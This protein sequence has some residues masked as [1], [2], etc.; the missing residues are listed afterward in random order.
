[1][2]M[3]IMTCSYLKQ[4][5]RNIM[6]C[7]T[8]TKI[9]RVL[10]LLVIL[11]LCLWVKYKN[12]KAKEMIQW[13]T[14]IINSI[15]VVSFTQSQNADILMEI[16]AELDKDEIGSAGG[17]FASYN[18]DDR[19]IPEKG[20]TPNEPKEPYVQESFT[21][22]EP[23]EN[24]TEKIPASFNQVIED[25]QRIDLSVR[26]FAS[27]NLFQKQSLDLIYK[28]I[29]SGRIKLDE[30]GEEVYYILEESR[31][32]DGELVR[33]VTDEEVENFEWF[34]VTSNGDENEG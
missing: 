4:I 25:L 16:I 12:D 14:K 7:S 26:T 31:Y 21:M 2:K 18:I 9:L 30:L 33:Q 6:E 28:R 15:G 20:P 34:F 24:G 8:K 29:S 22:F 32:D 3:C 5:A 17:V 1:M 11:S 23:D 19:P 27:N 10:N 13:N